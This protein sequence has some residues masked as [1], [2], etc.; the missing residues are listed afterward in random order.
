MGYHGAKY[1]V[2]GLSEAADHTL[3]HL[4]PSQSHMLARFGL[5]HRRCAIHQFWPVLIVRTADPD[6]T[7]VLSLCSGLFTECYEY[8]D[9][10]CA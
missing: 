4:S 3:A 10:T 2:P 7:S 8:H 1:T 6:A 9:G 5:W